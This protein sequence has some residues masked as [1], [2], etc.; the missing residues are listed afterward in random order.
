MRT[1]LL[2]FFVDR[3]KLGNTF[4]CEIVDFSM[5]ILTPF[6]TGQYKNITI[7]I[8]LIP[9]CF[10]EEA[11]RAANKL[12][13]L[14]SK[15]KAHKVFIVLEQ[16]KSVKAILIISPLSIILTSAGQHHWNI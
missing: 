6:M 1:I 8:N 9:A 12:H 10:V 7:A 3:C 13:L 2:K 5:G 4:K 11:N 15:S 14:S 16:N